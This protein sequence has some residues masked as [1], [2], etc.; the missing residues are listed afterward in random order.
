MT[1]AA[2]ATPAPLEWRYNPW[3]ERPLLAA[4]ALAFALGSLALLVSLGE[5][6]VLTIGLGTAAVASFAPLFTVAHC[7]VADGEVARRGP[8]GWARRPWAVVRRARLTRRGLLVSPYAEPH[9]LDVHRALYLPLPAAAA[10]LADEL[11]REL[12]AHGF[13]R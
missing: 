5:S 1:A 6:W 8:L 11:Q 7:R 10:E 3:R 9:W 4:T 13:A 12:S 2:P